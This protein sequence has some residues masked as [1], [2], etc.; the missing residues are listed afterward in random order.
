MGMSMPAAAYLSRDES[1]I[2]Q[3]KQLNWYS[4]SMK[5]NVLSQTNPYIRDKKKR[6]FGLIVSVGSSSAIEGIPAGR[7]IQDYLRRK[8]TFA[9]HHK[10]QE[11]G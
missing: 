7:L 4:P 5:K 9:T 1:I 11:N 8:K 10:P 6:L 2:V 3:K